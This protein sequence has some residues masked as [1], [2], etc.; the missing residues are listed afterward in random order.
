MSLHHGTCRNSIRLSVHRPACCGDRTN[1]KRFTAFQHVTFEHITFQHRYDSTPTSCIVP[2]ATASHLIRL[3]RFAR[4]RACPNPCCGG[5]I[6][7]WLSLYPNALLRLLILCSPFAGEMPRARRDLSPST[8][9]FL[10][11]HR[12]WLLMHQYLRSD[13]FYSISRRT[14]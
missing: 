9:P 5:P 4:S 6:H 1:T 2:K 12:Y 3:A 11:L 8:V 7:P 13:L 10:S 14:Y